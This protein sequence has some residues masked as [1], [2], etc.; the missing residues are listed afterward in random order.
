MRRGITCA[1]VLAACLGTPELAQGKATGGGG[2]ARAGTQ[3]KGGKGGG[4]A[5]VA[6]R[7]PRRSCADL[8][9]GVRLP[10]SGTGFE[11]P[12]TWDKRGLSWGTPQLV[13][14]IK[15]VAE[16][17]A[18][19]SDV[20]LRVADISPR[21]GGASAWHKSHRRGVDAD[22]LFY[23][24]D[25]AGNPAPEPRAM[26]VFDAEGRGAAR[27]NLGNDM[28]PRRFDTARNWK[29]VRALLEDRAGNVERILVARTMQKLL[30]DH[31]REIGAPAKLIER[32]AAT[33]HEPTRAPPHDDHFHVR[34]A[35]P[36]PPCTVI[37][38][39]GKTRRRR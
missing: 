28:P 4:K 36:N 26:L 8:P 38:A 35:D 3:G 22:I 19:D 37:A 15:R 17:L 13:G 7:S 6:A 14:L 31:A 10:A 20:P 23:M 16:R 33:F 21:G 30:L 39:R 18:E 9:R 24:L 12:T 34:I 25:G 2:G 1:L 27:D 5:K 11:I 29:L 32:A